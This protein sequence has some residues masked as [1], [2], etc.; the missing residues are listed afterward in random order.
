MKL[1]CICSQKKPASHKAHVFTNTGMSINLNLCNEHD[2]EL[3]KLGQLKFCA[4]YR[5]ALPKNDVDQDG[6]P[7]DAADPLAFS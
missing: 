3:F 7:S 5:V 2:I 4:K 1:C 6:N